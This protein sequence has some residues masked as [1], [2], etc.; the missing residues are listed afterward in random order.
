MTWE[1]ACVGV[2]TVAVGIAA[3]QV[4]VL[5][6]VLEEGYALGIPE[7]LEPD[8]AA[9]RALVLTAL[10]S[11]AMLAGMARRGLALVDGNG[12]QRVADAILPQGGELSTGH[13]GRQ[14]A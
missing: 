14:R 1:R 13:H 2:P 8:V 9:I 4:P 6:R 7:M 10:R 12:V 3:N 11:P 5:K